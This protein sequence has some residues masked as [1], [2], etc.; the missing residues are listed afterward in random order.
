MK[1]ERLEI[2][3]RVLGGNVLAI[4]DFDPETEFTEFERRYV[5]EFRPVYVSCKIP[6]ERISE[7]QIL[8]SQGFGV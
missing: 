3:S 6:L 4:S 1:A 2:D 7:I 5:E 8:E